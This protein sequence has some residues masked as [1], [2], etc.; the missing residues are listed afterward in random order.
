MA[1][2]LAIKDLFPR[3]KIKSAL[4]DGYHHFPA[5]DL[6][7]QVSI[8][9]VFTG[10]V[11]VVVVRIGI[12]GRE[13]LEPDTKV[14]MQAAFIVVDK[15]AAGNVHAVDQ[16]QAFFNPAGLKSILHLWSNVHEAH[17]GGQIQ[18]EVVGIGFHV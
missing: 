12:K 9:I 15:N 17:L 13:L 5:H 2:E 1:I 3:A 10:A 8:G 16:R 18:R 11:V 6:T 4:R 14:V 7:F